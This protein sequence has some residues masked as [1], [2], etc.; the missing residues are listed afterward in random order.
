VGWAVALGLLKRL[1]EQPHPLA[2]LG[3]F[4]LVPLTSSLLVFRVTAWLA[5]KQRQF[6][7]WLAR[8]LLS[9][10]ILF[11]VSFAVLLFGTMAIDNRVLSN[12]PGLASLLFWAIL[13]LL[14]GLGFVA[15]IPTT[16]WL[17]HSAQLS[18]MPRSRES[19]SLAQTMPTLK[20][21]WPHLVVSLFTM[22]VS[23]AITIS[24]VA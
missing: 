21:A 15:L 4:Y 24:L 5:A 12:L 2:I 3:V 17:A 1:G 8:S 7:R 20:R 11:G 10:I 18:W 23:L 9:E 16:Y 6:G 13:S 19:T 22:V 14:A